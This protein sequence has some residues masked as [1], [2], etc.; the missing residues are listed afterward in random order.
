MEIIKK[1]LT[2]H[3]VS[4]FQFTSIS[5]LKKLY[6]KLFPHYSHVD[7]VGIRKSVNQKVQRQNFNIDFSEVEIE[8]SYINLD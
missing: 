6:A 1:L 4:K 5:N 3:H 8:V 7:T 2:N